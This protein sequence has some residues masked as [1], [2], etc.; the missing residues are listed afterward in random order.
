MPKTA[1]LASCLVMLA[2]IAPPA[3][4]A[5]LS[6]KERARVARSAPRDRSEVRYCLLQRK[7]GTKKGTIIG[8]AGGAGV[9][10]IAGGGLGETALAAGA[11]ALVGNRVGHGSNSK[12][13]D[14]VLR[15][16]P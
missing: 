16:N 1:K 12:A 8:A 11:G 6:S 9:G 5:S 13:C 7:K 4:A 10:L 3:A 14:R 2:L 15:R